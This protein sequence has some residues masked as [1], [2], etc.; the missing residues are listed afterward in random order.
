MSENE[1]E[2]GVLRGDELGELEE[3][4]RVV[5]RNVKREDKKGRKVM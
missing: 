3:G 2:R 5:V 1:E 4:E